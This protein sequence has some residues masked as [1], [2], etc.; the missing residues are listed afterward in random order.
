VPST[1]VQ[2]YVNLL[3]VSY[4]LVRV[5]AYSVNRTKR[6]MKS[7]KL[8]WSDTGLAL[9]L[10]GESEARGAHL[11]NVVL[12]DLL[13]WSAT[14]SPRT[15]V[16]HWRTSAGAEVDFVLER[17]RRLLPVEVKASAR[18][19]IGDARHLRTFMTEYARAAPAALLLYDGEETFWLD[20][21]VL[22][23]PWHRVI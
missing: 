21:G 8:Y 20:R 17:G 16:L 15:A 9:H 14:A 10:A 13:A 7:P 18:L 1:T 3:E 22:A 4:Q 5:P 6:L 2:R 12:T 11:E 23:A 19:S